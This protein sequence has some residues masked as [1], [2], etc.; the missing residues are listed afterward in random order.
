MLHVEHKFDAGRD[1][2]DVLATGAAAPR[3]T[4]LK[5]GERDLDKAVDIDY[6]H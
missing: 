2:I 3:K 1:S 4:K 6:I 5:L